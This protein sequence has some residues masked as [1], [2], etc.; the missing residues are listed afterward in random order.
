M[1][2][3]HFSLSQNCYSQEDDI[4]SHQENAIE[5][6]QAKFHDGH[7]YQRT[8]QAGEQE[9]GSKQLHLSENQLQRIRNIFLK[10]WP[11]KDLVPLH[12]MDNRCKEDIEGISGRASLH[13]VWQ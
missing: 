5:S 13:T 6:S 1:N 3:K 8:N 10:T 12:I 2:L 11:F 7:C 9:D 4:D